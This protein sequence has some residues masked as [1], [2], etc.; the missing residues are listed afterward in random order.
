MTRNDHHAAGREDLEWLIAEMEREG[1]P[2]G[3]RERFRSV[4][5]DII[6]TGGARRCEMRTALR[7]HVA[8]QAVADDLP[9]PEERVLSTIAVI[10]PGAL[11]RAKRIDRAVQLVASGASRRDMVVILCSRFGCQRREAYRIIDRAMDLAEEAK[12]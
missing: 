9:T 8:G 11:R 12:A 4:I 5:T 6:E 7:A 3:L 1:I 10:N 2:R